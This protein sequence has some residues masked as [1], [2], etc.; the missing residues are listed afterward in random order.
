VLSW[1]DDRSAQ[2]TE[3]RI[4]AAR[5]GAPSA[6][7]A[8]SRPAPVA[9][10]RP[11]P[12]AGALAGTAPPVTRPAAIDGERPAPAGHQSD[13]AALLEALR[14]G[15]AVPTIDLPALTPA[16]MELIGQLLHEAVRGTVDLLNARAAIKHELRADVTTIVARNNNPLKFSPN[17]EIALQHLLAPPARGFIAALPAMRDAYDDLRAHQFG[18]VAGTQAVLEAALQRFDPAALE[19][20]L[21]D[22]SLLQS[23]L[24]ASRSARLWDLFTQHYARIRKDASDDFHTLFGH[25]FVKAYE[26]QVDRLHESSPKGSE[27]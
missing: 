1:E 19:S 22:R 18:I 26:E 12:P 24:P 8:P 6:P 17:A 2:Q 20:R 7:S 27:G 13:G 9:P 3:L 25:A 15:L 14:R 4:K 11:L 16:L 10:P 21:G 23:L 5:P